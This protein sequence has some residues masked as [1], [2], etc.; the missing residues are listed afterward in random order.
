MID[1]LARQQAAR[2]WVILAIV[3]AISAAF[4]FRASHLELRTRYDQMLPD[5]QPS[6]IGRAHV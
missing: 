1:A 5:S 6:E 3:F 4:G 2:P